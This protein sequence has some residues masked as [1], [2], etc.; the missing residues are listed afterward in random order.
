MLKEQEAAE[1]LAN[2]LARDSRNHVRR[3]SAIGLAKLGVHD[4]GKHLVDALTDRD[5]LVRRYAAEGLVKLDYKPAIP[6]LMFALEANIAGRDINKAL[7]ALTGQ[8]FGFNHTAN[9]I[10]RTEAV[11]RCFSWWAEHHL[12][13]VK[14]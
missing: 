8:D 13:F 1:I 10:D 9:I 6:Y 11:D 5:P 3:M 2:A 12:E 14:E 7:M 4:H